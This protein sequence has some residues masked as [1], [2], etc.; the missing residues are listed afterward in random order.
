MTANS[1]A[2]GEPVTRASAAQRSSLAATSRP[3]AEVERELADL[4][5]Q[6]RQ[7]LA[8][9]KFGKRFFGGDDLAALGAWAYGLFAQTARGSLYPG[10]LGTTSMVR[11]QREIVDNTLTLLH[12]PDDAAGVIT[13]G[14]TESVILAVKA[15]VAQARAQGLRAS[16]MQI[17]ASRSAHPCLDKAAELLGV[18]LH[19]IATKKDLT[20][21]VDAIGACLVPRTVM[22]YASFP[23]YAYGSV[24]DIQLL[25]A[26]A[27]KAGV[28]LHVD[29]CMSGF[30]APFARMNGETIPEFDFRVPGVGSIS[31]DLHKHGYSAKGAST[32]LFSSSELARYHFFSYA[33]HPLPPM[34]TPTLAGTAAG[35]PIASAWAI[36]RRL[37]ID[38][39]RELTRRLFS[40]RRA[41]VAAVKSVPG[42]DVLDSPLFSIV[43][44]TS[45]EHDLAHVRDCLTRRHWC[46]LPVSEPPGIHLNIGAHDEPLA[47]ELAR[48]LRIAVENGH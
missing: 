27:H 19:R 12:A 18:K 41:V 28:W 26:L 42:F 14:G 40:A 6:D 32:L 37:G 45:A 20:A 35:A 2:A 7:G 10:F 36:M 13:S 11:M 44:V 5:E 23:S 21:D 24:D 9:V 4:L 30:L 43:V 22:I 39:Y 33:D 16:E 29:A 47:A 46:T 1:S 3:R 48:D 31:A 25:G 8:G 34:V 15:C 17:I 38:G